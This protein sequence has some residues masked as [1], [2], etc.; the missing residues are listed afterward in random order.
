MSQHTKQIEWCLK[1][2]KKEINECKKQGKRLKHRGLLEANADI[3]E[4]KK[5]LAKAEHNLIGIS[6][7]KEIGFSDCL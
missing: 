6:R 3:D 1:K 4:A 2:A 7:F 5:H